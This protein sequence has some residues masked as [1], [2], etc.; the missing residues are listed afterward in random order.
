MEKGREYYVNNANYKIFLATEYSPRK[1]LVELTL[2]AKE[3]RTTKELLENHFHYANKRDRE[4]I[5]AVEHRRRKIEVEEPLELPIKQEMQDNIKFEIEPSQNGRERSSALVEAGSKAR[6]KREPTLVKAGSKA[7]V[8]RKPASTSVR[9][10]SFLTEDSQIPSRTQQAQAVIKQKPSKVSATHK[11]Q[12]SHSSELSTSA[13]NQAFNVFFDDP[14]TLIDGKPDIRDSTSLDDGFMNIADSNPNSPSRPSV[15]PITPPQPQKAEMK[16]L[17]LSKSEESQS[18]PTATPVSHG[19]ASNIRGRSRQTTATTAGNAQRTIAAE[20]DRSTHILAAERHNANR[21]LMIKRKNN[22]R[23]APQSTIAF[24]N[25]DPSTSA[26]RSQ[27]GIK[28]RKSES[29]AKN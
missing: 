24:V 1:E 25:H 10:A 23:P 22:R 16:S 19:A 14:L 17:F 29:D 21:I 4:L 15:S 11:R 12:M 13:A 3:C 9:K 7:R 28:K 6:V 18:S 26:R 27:R 20:G 8:K 5:I 2:Q